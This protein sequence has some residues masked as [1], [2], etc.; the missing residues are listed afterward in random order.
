MTDQGRPKPDPENRWARHS[1]TLALWVMV[2]IMSI[3]AT[4]LTSDLKNPVNRDGQDLVHFQTNIPGNLDLVPELRA[5][6]L[7]VEVEP[8]TTPLGTF[9]LRVLPWLLFIAFWFWIFKTMQAGG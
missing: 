5:H 7:V 9:I 4:T 8:E 6:N 1:K 3:L 2:V